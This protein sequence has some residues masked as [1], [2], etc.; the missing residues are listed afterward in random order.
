MNN[1]LPFDIFIFI[2]RV[3]FI[4]LLYLFLFMVVRVVMREFNLGGSRNRTPDAPYYSDG[5][6]DS[7][8]RPPTTNLPPPAP[9]SLGRLV[10][11]ATGNATTLKEG[12]IVPLREVMPVGKRAGTDGLPLND[13]FVS[14]EHALF[15]WRDGQWWLSDV[16]STNGTY[17]N[18]QR[19][20]RPTPI[21]FGDQI[22]IGRVRFQLVR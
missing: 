4:T 18:G 22:G 8:P 12:A 15:A 1:T 14:G 11:L 7:A 6:A 17:I 20:D 16:A 9:D 21:Q 10:V 2:L 19:I 13:D 5:S 3:S